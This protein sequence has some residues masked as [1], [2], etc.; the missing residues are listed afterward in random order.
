MPPFM[1]AAPA[2]SFSV[3]AAVPFEADAWDDLLNHIEEKRVI[4]I[5]GPELLIVATESGPQLL[6]TWLAP[7]LA[8]RLGIP[9]EELP[10]SERTLALARA[11]Q[12]LAQLDAAR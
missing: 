12:A 10:A 7:R 2:S 6:Y 1:L 3:S 8:A 5:I 9:P 4:P 11:E